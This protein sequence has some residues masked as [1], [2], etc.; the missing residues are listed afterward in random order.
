M[1]TQKDQYLAANLILT[2]RC[3]VPQLLRVRSGCV[4]ITQSHDSTDH[5][6]RAGESML[7][8][9][10]RCVIEAL[11]DSHFEFDA[12]MASAASRIS[13]LGPVTQVCNWWRSPYPGTM[14]GWA[15]RPFK[16]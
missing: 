3:P 12:P 1:H 5:F 10:E 4:W 15:Q 8:H 14:A 2:L 16:G 6:I 11:S 7:L 13:T 9:N